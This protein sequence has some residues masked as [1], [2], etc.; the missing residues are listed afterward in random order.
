[1]AFLTSDRV[2]VPAVTA[3]RMREI[4]R[5]AI[6]ET[7][8]SLLQML[9]HAGRSL[10]EVALGLIGKPLDEAVVVVL[11]GRG[12]NGAGGICAARHLAARVERVVLSISEPNGLIEAARIQRSIFGHTGGRELGPAELDPLRPDLVLDALIGYGLS[13]A[14]H[15]ETARLI[16]WANAQ[17]CPVLSL[18]VPSG[19]DA[20]TGAAPGVAV[21]PEATLTLALPKTGLAHAATGRLLL[22][23]IGI[24]EATFRRAGVRR[25]PFGRGFVI[26][27]RT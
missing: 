5:I 22:A 24:P 18:D 7:G 19:I 25:A 15:G 3:D 10:A 23:D 14:P 17:P 13:A 11:A 2:E 26:P 16:D 20:T 27:L 21:T 6:E 12:G 1:M 4:D 8:P 9:E